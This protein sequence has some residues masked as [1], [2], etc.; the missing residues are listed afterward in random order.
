MYGLVNKAIEG[1]I[2][3]EF[4]IDTW[5]RIKRRANVDL[6]AFISMEPYSDEITYRLVGA[7][8][9][10]IGKN[11]AELLKQ[12]GEY[13]ILYTAQEGYGDLLKISG[14]T[15]REF[16]FNLDNLHAHIGISFPVLMPPSFQCYDIDEHTLLLK[17]FST[18]EGLA[19]MVLGLIIGLGKLFIIELDVEHSL[20]RN[21]NNDHD[22]FIIKL[23]K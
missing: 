10:E 9:E 3:Q 14:R 5:E 1:M 2:C 18:R 13:W 11:G 16:L 23:R 12:F 19:P 15:F 21:Q 7:A 20:N 17:Y 22:E 4:G 6:Q 8:S